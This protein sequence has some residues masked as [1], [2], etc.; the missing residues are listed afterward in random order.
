M[1]DVYTDLT[2]QSAV[3][4]THIEMLEMCELKKWREEVTYS[5]VEAKILEFHDTFDVSPD[6]E[7]YEIE[8]AAKTSVALDKLIENHHLGSMA[9]YYEGESGNEYE[10][11]VTSVMCHRF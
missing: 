3:F 10:N 8:R 2:K 7:V 4:G 5:E 6:C 9:Y 11:I 1:L